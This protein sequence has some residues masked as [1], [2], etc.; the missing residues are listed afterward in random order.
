MEKKNLLEVEVGFPRSYTTGGS[1]E[2]EN[3]EDRATLRCSSGSRRWYRGS[4]VH[5]DNCQSAGSAIIE[6]LEIDVKQD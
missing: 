6:G 3:I 1:E 2:C 4:T 5:R